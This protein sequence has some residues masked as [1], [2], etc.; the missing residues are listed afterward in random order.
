MAFVIWAFAWFLLSLTQ[1]LPMSTPISLLLEKY[2]LCQGVSIDSRSLAKDEMFFAL[3]GE[4]FNGNTYAEKALTN[5]AMFVVVDEEEY[6]TDTQ[7]MFLVDNSLTAMQHLATAY[8]KTFGI[9]VIGITGSNG[10][11]TTKELLFTVLNSHY[12]AYCTS[13][14]LNNHIGVP[15]TLLRM[16]RTTQIAVIEMGANH[17]GE[18]EMLSNI[19]LPTHGLITNIGKA[20]LE[21]FGGI[22]GVK[23]G[24]SELYHHIK[25][26]NGVVFVNKGAKF[27]NE[28]SHGIPNKITYGLEDDGIEADFTFKKI[29]NEHQF[30]AVVWDGTLMMSNL[31]GEYNINNIITALTV[32]LYFDVPVEQMRLAIEGYWPNNNRSQIAEHRGAKV[33]MDAYNAN[34]TSMESSLLNFD[35]IPFDGVKMAIVGEMLELGEDSKK[36]HQAIAN[37][38]GK[39]D[40]DRL[41]FAGGSFGG[42]DL[43]SGAL[44]FPNTASLR[45]WFAGQDIRGMFLLV[46]GSRGNKLETIFQP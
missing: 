46:K 19:A 29:P 13:G 31:A 22:E 15:L 43:P 33:L 20:H 40:L 16:P 5:G 45:D 8:R 28:L 44:F 30:A 11:T 7:R 3:K 14:N 12:S 17:Q 35:S 41:V 42:I 6:Y 10:K 27:L 25:S 21:G 24:K 32:G 36:E 38:C 2:L 39:L 26:N 9:P 37:L 18:I 4:N 1:F 34:P 23:K